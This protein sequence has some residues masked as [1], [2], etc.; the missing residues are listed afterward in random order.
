MG[1]G[2]D[3]AF[4]S[5]HQSLFRKQ[6]VLDAHLPHI[7]VVVDVEAAGKAAALLALLRGFDILVGN[8]VI[9]DHGNSGFVEYL[10]KAG[11]FKFV[12]GDRRGDIVAQHHIQIGPDQLSGFYGIQ[13]RVSGQD[14]LR[15]CHTHEILSF[16]MRCFCGMFISAPG[17]PACG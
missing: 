15:H 2:A 4:A 10:R 7:V 14:F 5:S 12:D 8:K 9:H 13:A 3:D 16:L 11:L 17:L 1:V 6:G